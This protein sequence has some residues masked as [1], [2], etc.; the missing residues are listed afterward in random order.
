MR[1]THGMLWTRNEAD[2]ER[3]LHD[4]RYDEAEEK[5]RAAAQHAR[6]AG[7]DDARLAATLYRLAVVAERRGHVGEALDLYR[8]A[9]AIEERALGPDH[10]Y[11]AMV[12]GSY[13]ALLR[14]GG[15]A[16]QAAALEARARSIWRGGA[17]G[18][19]GEST[20]VGAG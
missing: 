1:A 11:V 17:A 12:L 16:T 20:D 18:R 7:F 4:G 3:L 2:G 13:A 5:L 9:L 8:R 6:A 14:R 10:P 15:Q 19:S